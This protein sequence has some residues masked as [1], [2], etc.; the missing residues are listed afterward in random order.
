MTHDT[1]DLHTNGAA[2]SAPYSIKEETLGTPR[3][4]RVIMIGAGASGLN[5]ARHME[6]HMQNYQLQLYEKNKDIGGTWFENRYPGCACDIPSHNYQ[7]SWEPNPEWSTFYSQAGEIFKYFKNIAI[8]YDLYKYI[9]LDHLVTGAVWDE[10]KGIWNLKIT[11]NTT[12]EIVC[13]WAHILINGCGVLNNWKWP[14]IPG[15]HSFKGDLI[16]SAAWPEDYDYNKKNVAVLGCGS[17]GVQIVPTIQPKVKSLTTFIRT[18][19][20]ITAGFAQSH[21]GPGGANFEFTEEQKKTFRENPEKYLEYRRAIEGELNKRFRF[22]IVDSKEQAEAREY[23]IRD[24]TTKLGN[25]PRLVKALLPNFAVGCRRPTPGNGYLESLTKENVRVVTDNISKV[26]PEGIVLSTGEVLKVDSFICATGFDMSFAPRFDLVG[27]DGKRLT[28]QWK[29]K[30]TAYLSL[31][32]ANFPNY[33]MFLGPNAPIGHGSVLPIV[34]HSTKYMINFMKKIQSQCIK[35]V[36]PKPEA[37][38]E[39]D[40]HI[41]EFM[42]RTAWA[43]PC[44]SWFKNGKIDG[45]VIAVHPGSRVHWF[46]LMDDIRYEDWEYTY[47]SNNRFQYLGNGFSIREDPGKDTTDYLALPD[48]GYRDY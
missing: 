48:K 3:K 31:A 2:S 40:I 27:R 43:T 25:D 21:A 28:E 45:P 10:E 16:H 37:I 24:M 7:Y 8:K 13:D 46:H 1:T 5:L 38:R 47:F 17:S 22:V 18:P 4:L 12:R 9:R 20:W 36:T 19:T 33:F 35:A 34:E 39:Y 26:V 15:L 41:T 29:E 32:A 44:R 30:P 14:D 42:K 6:L 23:S 11:N